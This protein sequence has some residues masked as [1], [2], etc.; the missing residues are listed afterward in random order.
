M[1]NGR[2]RFNVADRFI[3]LLGNGSSH[4]FDLEITMI[5][6]DEKSLNRVAGIRDPEEKQKTLGNTFIDVRVVLVVSCLQ[7]ESDL[8]RCKMEF[9]GNVK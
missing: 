1:N 9:Y 3:E 5:N 8:T 2:R 4:V 7:P 6:A